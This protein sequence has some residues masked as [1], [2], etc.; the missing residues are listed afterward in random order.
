MYFMSLSS[1]DRERLRNGNGD[2]QEEEEAC[3]YEKL[4]AQQFSSTQQIKY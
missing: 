4:P 1:L 2:I 3:E